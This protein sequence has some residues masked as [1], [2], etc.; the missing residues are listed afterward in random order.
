MT[1]AFSWQNSVSC[2]LLHF[3]LKAKL[4]CYSRYLLTSYNCIPVHYN[5]RDISFG[6]QFQKVLQVFIELFNFSFFSISDWGI[7]VDYCDIEWFALETNR[8][9]FCFLCRGTFC[10]CPLWLSIYQPCSEDPVSCPACLTPD[11]SLAINLLHLVAE[12]MSCLFKNY[13]EFEC[14]YWATLKGWQD[15]SQCVDPRICTCGTP[16]N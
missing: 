3:V 4:A 11:K 2:A 13:Y 14:G 5:E 1:S 15:P 7:D 10:S 16:V 9:G 12:N 8:E 6:C